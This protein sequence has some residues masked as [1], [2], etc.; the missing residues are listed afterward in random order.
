MSDH[1][2]ILREPWPSVRRQ[3]EGVAFGMWI[4]LATEVLF[5]GA[6]ILIYAVDRH[7][8][9]DAFVEAARQTN[10]VYGTVNTAL[11][12]T[13]SFVMTVALEG[14]NLG[15][16]RL[17][18]A[19]MAA[20]AALG[21]AFLVVKGFEYREDIVEHLVPGAQLAVPTATGQ[22]FFALY[23]VM[24]GIHAIH[25]AI[26]IALVLVMIGAIA[27]GTLTPESPAIE[28]SALYWHFVDTVWVVLYALI[29]LPGRS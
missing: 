16:R 10:I 9:P 17:V 29:Y 13:S 2:H 22:L 19:G 6:L 26:G 3:R 18:I 15:S 25:L 24:T 23:W 5:F 28:A 1:P 8:Y 20:T 7:L 27:H 12:L 11:L 21:T 14:S 4:F